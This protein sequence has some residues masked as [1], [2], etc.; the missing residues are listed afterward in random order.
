MGTPQ[1]YRPTG[2]WGFSGDGG[3]ATRARL[4]GPTSLFADAAGVLFLADQGNHRIRAVAPDGTISTVVGIGAGKSGDGGPAAQAAL[5]SPAGVFVSNAGDLYIADTGNHRIRRVDGRTGIISTAA[6]TGTAGYSGDGGPAVAAQVSSPTRL[7]VDADGTVFFCDEGNG[8]VRRI[9]ADGTIS[10]AVGTGPWGASADGVPATG[11]S[12]MSPRAIWVDGRGDL[13]LAE[14]GGRRLRRVP[15]IAAPTVLT[16]AFAPPD[17][18]HR[19]PP[20]LLASDPRDGATDVDPGRLDRDGIRLVFSWP[21]DSLSVRAEMRYPDGAVQA[22]RAE[23]RLDTVRAVRG[24]APPVVGG[25]RY[26]LTVSGIRTR[27]GT[28]SADTTVVLQTAAVAGGDTLLGAVL[29]TVAGTGEPGFWGDGGPAVQARLQKPTDVCVDRQGNVLVADSSNARIRRIGVD[30]VIT[31]VAGSGQFRWDYS[32][33]SQPAVLAPLVGSG[34]VAFAP[35]GGFY[36]SRRGDGGLVLR[37]SPDGLVSTAAGTGRWGFSGDGG[38]ATAAGVSAPM[39]VFVDAAGALLVTDTEDNRVRHVGRDGIISTVAGNGEWDYTG[40]GQAAVSAS[41]GM[42]TRAFV[43]NAGDLYIADTGN[44]CIRRVD[45]QTGLISTVAGTGVVGCA[46]DGGAAQEALLNRPYGLFVD[47]QGTLFFCDQ[48]NHR[49]CRIGTDGTISTVAG[50]GQRGLSPDGVAAQGAPLAW[51]SAV[52]VDGHGDLIIAE[53]GNHRIRCL[54]GVAAPTVLKGVFAPA[55]SGQ[56][57]SPRLVSSDPSDG[58]SGVAADTLNLLGVTLCFESPV[59]S[60]ATDLRLVALGPDGDL[61]WQAFLRAGSGCMLL[62]RGAAAP[63]AFGRSYAVVAARRGSAPGST[64]A[65]T[66]ITFST[67]PAPGMAD[68]VPPSLQS[69]AVGPRR[70][71]GV[72]LRLVFSEPLDP[73]W[74]EAAAWLGAAEVAWDSL[75]AVDSLLTLFVHVPAETPAGTPC[76]VVVS[77]VRDRAANAVPPVSLAFDL[78]AW[79]DRPDTL[80]APGGTVGPD[81]TATPDTLAVPD[82]TGAPGATGWPDTAATADTVSAPG[83]T[84]RPDTAA[85]ADTATVPGAAVEP[86]STAAL[87]A[88]TAPGTVVAPAARMALDFDPAEGDQEVRW[89]GG[90]RRRFRAQLVV[91]EA[92]EAAGWSAVLRYDAAVLAYVPGSFRPGSFIPGLVPL[93]DDRPGQLSIGGSV[94]GSEGRGSGAGVLGEL[95]LEVVPWF[96][97]E[98][99]LELTDVRLRHPDGA[100]EPCQTA[101]VATIACGRGRPLVTFDLDPRP[102]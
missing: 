62:A 95:E 63:V 67:R 97:G 20:W 68:P 64:R 101:G 38:P 99:Y 88:L 23:A 14:A 52:F 47:A 18:A 71:D 8:R 94:L 39:G 54:R 31:T 25:S 102:G 53:T 83:A 90:A 9:D 61:G 87:D 85:A 44:H 74:L 36:L 49:V 56:G 42:P 10:T 17:A 24:S 100:L 35:D 98:A 91:A 96:S 12:L 92:P 29:M 82:T 66:L 34:A 5:Q 4:S 16:G 69:H 86:D 65:D 32:G 80:A 19:P 33:D 51:P 43:D 46:G 60:A 50:T 15:G 79:P 3:P 55:P 84:V 21:V 75:A 28:V 30:G 77:G 1:R 57:A 22:W 89:T 2:E 70:A 78:P 45:G 7:F 26:I 27:G 40:D 81:S 13:Y 73:T 59:D 41:L 48:G 11:A 6:G 37:V 58:S 72:G 93:A 76:R